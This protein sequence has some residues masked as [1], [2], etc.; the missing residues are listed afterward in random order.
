[1]NIDWRE[2]EPGKET[3]VAESEVEREVRLERTRSQERRQG[4]T[5]AESEEEREVSLEMEREQG[6]KKGYK[7]DCGCE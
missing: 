7:A 5:V 6:A 3:K 2:K 4:W 1:M